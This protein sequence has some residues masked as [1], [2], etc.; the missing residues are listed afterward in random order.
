MRIYRCFYDAELAIGDS[1]LLPEDESKHLGMVRRVQAGEEIIVLNG[2]GREVIAKVENA[3]RKGMTV[4]IDRVEQQVPEPRPRRVLICALTKSNDYDE[5]LQRATELGMTEFWPLYTERTVVELDEGRFRKKAGRWQRMMIEGLKQ[6]ERLWLPVIEDP[7]DLETSL[8]YCREESMRP[9]LLAERTPAAPPLPKVLAKH[10][11][12]DIAYFV[13]PEGGWAPQEWKL[14]KDA[15]VTFASLT[16]S[17]I[18]R[19]ETAAL[20]ALAIAEA[21]TAD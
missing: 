7:A 11:A 18:L 13:G 4:R 17:A 19:S 1:L 12:E 14:F 6:C 3:H 2:R 10:G 21:W 9:V 5:M 15:E 16:H 8:R 20:A